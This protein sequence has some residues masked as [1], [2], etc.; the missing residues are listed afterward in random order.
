LFDVKKPHLITIVGPTAV[1]KTALSIKLAQHFGVNIISADSRQLYKYMN[2]G[3]A[4][5]TSS[6]LALVKHHMIDIAEPN[7]MY[8]AGQFVE[9]V[10]PILEDELNARGLVM[11]VGGSGMYISALI[12]GLDEMPKVS[13]G[14]RYQLTE[15]YDQNGLQPLQQELRI[16]DPDY[17]E[18]VDLKNPH[19]I[20]RAL[21]IIRSTGKPFSKFRKSKPSEHFFE[22]VLVG[23]KMDKEVLRE[24]INQRVEEMISNGLIDEV[25]QIER[26]WSENAL[27]TVG[28]QE[29]ITYLKG[30]LTLEDAIELI[31]K[32]THRYMKRQMTWFRKDQNI[33]W[34]APSE[35]NEIISHIEKRIHG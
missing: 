11:M 34:F 25:K 3:T 14:I 10:Y 29:I 19:R 21:E 12:Y 31:K 32:N 16:K 5:P 6:E 8:S 22:T 23:L 35:Y 17:Y 33:K 28:Y 20:I 13:S 4:K 7:E 18:Q 9:N 15:E 30:E 26:Y 2:I 27:K 24:R 1:G